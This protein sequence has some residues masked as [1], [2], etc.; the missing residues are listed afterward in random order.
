MIFFSIFPP[1]QEKTP[2]K[3]QSYGIFHPP[4][5]PV[6]PEVAIMGVMCNLHKLGQMLN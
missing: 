4:G 1:S 6:R 5:N 3:Y 2:E